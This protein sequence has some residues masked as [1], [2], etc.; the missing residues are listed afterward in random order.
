MSLYSSGP[1]VSGT[2]TMP[3]SCPQYMKH[4]PDQMA[5]SIAR[6]FPALTRYLGSSVVNLFI[7]RLLVVLFQ[8]AS[9]SGVCADNQ[10]LC[11]DNGSLEVWQG[12][13]EPLML[14]GLT[15]P[16]VHG[17]EVEDV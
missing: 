15:I 8:E 13:L 9:G 17:V 10:I 16:E 14:R 4:V 5:S 3:I 11:F 6:I 1:Q 12:G 7:L 2:L